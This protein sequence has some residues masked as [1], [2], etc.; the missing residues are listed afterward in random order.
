M[1]SGFELMLVGMGTVFGFLIVLVVL[2]EWLGWAAERWLPLDAEAVD[3]SGHQ[4]ERR[5]KMAVA[6]AVAL[7]R[8]TGK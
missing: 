7:S 4:R 6:A 3:N 8:R 2:L 1:Q 5:R